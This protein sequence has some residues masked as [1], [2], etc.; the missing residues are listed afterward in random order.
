MGF[1]INLKN[2]SYEIDFNSKNSIYLFT[3]VKETYIKGE[4][5]YAEII[6][7]IKGKKYYELV[8][9]E[10]VDPT[11]SLY[12]S[13]NTTYSDRIMRNI[14]E[15]NGLDPYDTSM[16]DEIMSQSKET[17]FSEYLEW[18]GIIGYSH[19]ILSVIEELYGVKL[20]EDGYDL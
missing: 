20:R 2:V 14:R 19:S 17:I 3:I 15:R 13:I 18:I 16:D 1:R 6:F 9:S 4:L 12:P 11:P 5:D 7:H 8:K 10:N